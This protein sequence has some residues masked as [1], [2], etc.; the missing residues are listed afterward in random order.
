MEGSWR[1]FGMMARV[2]CFQADGLLGPGRVDCMNLTRRVDV[3]CEGVDEKKW[4]LWVGPPS[5]RIRFYRLAESP[6]AGGAW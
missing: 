2:C 3:G 6:W 1:W 4:Q 5:M